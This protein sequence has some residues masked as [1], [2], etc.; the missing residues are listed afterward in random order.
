MNAKLIA[1]FGISAQRFLHD[2]CA[3]ADDAAVFL[4]NRDKFGRT[5]QLSVFVL[6][7]P[8]SASNAIELINNAEIVLFKAKSTG[9]NEIQYFDAPIIHDFLH[10]IQ[11]ENMLKGAMSQK[12][13]SLF[14]QPQYD[15]ESGRLRG[16]EALIRWKDENGKLISPAEFIPI[17]EN[18]YRC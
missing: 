16:V 6:P 18:R 10:H 3:N 17:A 11:I 7:V 2:P 8:E 13:F 12:Q 1:P 15:V 5:D 9:G 14:Y 4:G